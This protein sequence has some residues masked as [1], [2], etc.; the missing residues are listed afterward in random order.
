MKLIV[1]IVIIIVCMLLFMMEV[2]NYMF[3][4]IIKNIIC[5]F[6]SIPS[7]GYVYKTFNKFN[8]YE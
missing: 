3:I 2:N 8:T 5:I 1:H 7:I 6:I 4:W